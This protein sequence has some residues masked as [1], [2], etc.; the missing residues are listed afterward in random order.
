VEDAIEQLV[1]FAFADEDLAWMAGHG[2]DGAALDALARLRF[3]GDVH[4]VPEGRVVF[5]GE[6]LAEV[7]APIAEAQL[8]ETLLL[9]QITYQTAIATKAVRCRLAAPGVDLVD[10]A[11]RRTHGVE[12]GLSV[13][14]ACTM[15]HSYIEA[16][17]DEAEA[18]RAF[19]HD[20][21]G[22]ATFL[23]DT[24]DTLAG[25]RTAI[26]VIRE[27]D[28]TTTAAVRIDSG[29][30]AALTRATRRLLDD[31]GLPKVRILVSGG[32]DEY[33]LARLVAGR[34][35]IDAAGVGTNVG[36]SADAPTLDSVYKLV[37]DGDR[38]VMKLSPGKATLPGAKQVWRRPGRPDL[39]ATRDE[40]GPDGAEALLVPRLR[41]GRR[42]GSPDTIAAARQRLATDLD[43]LPA[44]ARDIAHPVAPDV[45]RSERLDRLTSQIT[46]R[47]RHR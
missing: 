1:S 28:L 22:A 39:L 29:D 11:L 38:P 32:L 4:A 14:R 8:V 19:A 35:P 5:A 7:T 23:V 30:L 25:V 44:G 3:T 9:N 2:F 40:A 12:A 33:S 13:A 36:V 43:A 46:A 47:H 31:A 15:A 18:F 41:A 37:A 27:L 42:V 20:R 26:G 6:P 21:P 34:A 24:Y 17:A 10:F 45:E 16:F